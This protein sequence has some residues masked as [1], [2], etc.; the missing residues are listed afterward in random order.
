MGLKLQSK[1]KKKN[2][3]TTPHPF[4]IWCFSSGILQLERCSTKMQGVTN[5]SLDLQGAEWASWHWAMWVLPFRS[6]HRVRDFFVRPLLAG[7]VLPVPGHSPWV[8][9]A[10]GNMLE[11]TLYPDSLGLGAVK[12]WLIVSTTSS[13]T[14]GKAKE[15]KGLLRPADTR[16]W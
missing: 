13:R 3:T 9:G 4:W 2:Q 10:G 15:A 5:R 6:A 16:V 11:V 14:P 8:V 12:Q 7:C 1:V